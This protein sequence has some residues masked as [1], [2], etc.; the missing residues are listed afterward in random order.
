MAGLMVIWILDS[1]GT[2]QLSAHL[3]TSNGN[4]AQFGG[5]G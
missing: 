5:G 3:Q 4:L 2:G 1:Y